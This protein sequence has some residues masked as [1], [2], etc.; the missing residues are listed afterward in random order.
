MTMKS[1]KDIIKFNIIAFIIGIFFICLTLWSRLLY[2]RV[3]KDLIIFTKEKHLVYIVIISIVLF[4]FLLLNVLKKLLKFESKNNSFFIPYIKKLTATNV[5]VTLK[6]IYNTYILQA[7]LHVVELILQYMNIGYYIERPTLYILKKMIHKNKIYLVLIMKFIPKIIIST[8][9]ITD[10]LYFCK[11]NYFYKALV[12]LLLPLF[13][14][15]Y[16]MITE[17]IALINLEFFGSHLQKKTSNE[18]GFDEYFFANQMPNIDNAID[19]VKHQH[20]YALLNWVV[21][22]YDIY[23]NIYNFI[24][25]IKV[26]ETKAN[27]YVNL[28]IFSCYLSGWLYIY[29]H[30][31]N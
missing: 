6:Y 9:F 22:N 4:L 30:Y 31:I 13:F 25:N 20:D 16:T 3:P 10:I 21:S 2:V 24:Q 27:P 8:L 15:F 14:T 18:T 19:I 23:G 5:V 17:K 28:Y 11:L 7:P 29:F 12:L 1:N 26:A